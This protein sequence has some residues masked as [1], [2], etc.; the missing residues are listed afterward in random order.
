MAEGNEPPCF[1]CREVRNSPLSH[2]S[3]ICPLCGAKICTSC[4]SRG[5]PFQCPA[6]GDIE[7][8]HEA[9][10][11]LTTAVQNQTVNGTWL[12]N[13]R[14]VVD[15]LGKGAL[16]G[17]GM[18]SAPPDPSVSRS[19]GPLALKDF[20]E[21]FHSEIA[22]WKKA[23]TSESAIVAAGSC[24]SVASQGNADHNDGHARM[25]RMVPSLTVPPHHSPSSTKPPQQNGYTQLPARG[26]SARVTCQAEI[27][28]TRNMNPRASQQ[29][30][31]TFPLP[32]SNSLNVSISTRASETD[33]KDL[34]MLMEQDEEDYAEFRSRDVR[35][36]DQVSAGDLFNLAEKWGHSSELEDRE[37][38]VSE[39]LV[40]RKIPS[41]C[42]GKEQDEAI[43][44]AVKV[45]VGDY[46][47]QY[48]MARSQ[49]S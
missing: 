14:S 20:T 24:P 4:I 10:R 16:D 48:P 6:C 25:A 47:K 5:V 3:H 13:F 23:T 49:L 22:W 32:F 29:A 12:S 42:T 43:D 1:L 46:H 34:Q 41:E 35:T 9:L 40:G 8:N 38:H 31:C 11:K 44:E 33:E 19:S 2:L 37:P 30:C 26:P 27:I 45:L 17:L 18:S 36:S 15:I 7:L 21:F 39:G 28:P